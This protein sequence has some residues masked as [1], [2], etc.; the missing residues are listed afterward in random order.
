MTQR[1]GRINDSDGSVAEKS[2]VGPI[3]DDS[4]LADSRVQGPTVTS[5]RH[6]DIMIK[7]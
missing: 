5:Q 7:P 3:G 4:K 6:S 1:Y 2:D